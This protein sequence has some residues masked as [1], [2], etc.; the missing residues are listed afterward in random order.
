LFQGLTVESS[1]PLIEIV[2]GTFLITVIA[3][4]GCAGSIVGLLLLSW[5]LGAVVLTRLGT[6]A[7]PFW[8]PFAVPGQ[9]GPPYAEPPPSPTP[10][11]PGRSGPSSGPADTKPLGELPP[12]RPQ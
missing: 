10:P 6:T 3:H 8:S 7:D 5:G 2:V 1:T 12:Q 11:R 4:I 9:P